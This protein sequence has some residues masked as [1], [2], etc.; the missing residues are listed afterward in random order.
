MRKLLILTIAL[1]VTACEHTTAT[2][3]TPGFGQSIAAAQHA[4]TDAAPPSTEAPQGS[5]AAGALAQTRYQTGNTRPLLPSSTS[6]NNPSS[7]GNH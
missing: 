3:G 6:S 5:G 4:Q 2:S 1:G 7:S